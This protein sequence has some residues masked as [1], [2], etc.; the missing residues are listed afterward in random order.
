MEAARFM[1]QDPDVVQNYDKL[2]LQSIALLKQ[3]SDAKLR[4]DVY[5][6]GQVREAV[7]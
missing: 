5:R 6:S 2:Y 1:Q 4:Q 3:L 7:S